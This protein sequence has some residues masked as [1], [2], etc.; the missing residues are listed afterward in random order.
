MAMQSA[1]SKEGTWK[2]PGRINDLNAAQ[3]LNVLNDLNLDIV[4]DLTLAPRRSAGLFE[5]IVAHPDGKELG[6]FKNKGTKRW[7]F[8]N[9]P[10]E[11]RPTPSSMKF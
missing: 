11:K 10:M 1:L 5:S 7:V 8:L 9:E 4:H 6:K 2:P 3:R